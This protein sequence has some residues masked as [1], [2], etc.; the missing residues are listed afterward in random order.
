[1]KALFYFFLIFV[2]T[3][4]S[5]YTATGQN[6]YQYTSVSEQILIEDQYFDESIT[7]INYTPAFSFTSYYSYYWWRPYRRYYFWSYNPYSWN[8]YGWNSWGWN[9]WNNY[10]WS[11]W[12]WNSWNNWYYHP[13][14]YNTYH[15]FNNFG[16]TCPSPFFMQTTNNWKQSLKKPTTDFKELAANPKSYTSIKP[17][18]SI[19][20]NQPARQSSNRENQ[21]LRVYNQNI[22]V[23]PETRS[24]QKNET[25]TYRDNHSAPH[26]QTYQEPQRRYETPVRSSYDRTPKMSQPTRS[27]QSQPRM[28]SPSRSYNT[29]PRMS[30]PSRNYAS[31]S[32]QSMGVKKGA[33]W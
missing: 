7:W 26:K 9:S 1:M 24:Y 10:G 31:P 16:P 23:K 28:A 29:Q 25:Q 11:S 21:D 32:R 4:C 27:Y 30:S 14:S 5:V 20:D 15:G 8:N 22:S 19:S 12:G 33:R 13:Y 2:L 6:P 3:S 18:K 17:V